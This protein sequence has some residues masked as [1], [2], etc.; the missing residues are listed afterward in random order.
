MLHALRARRN[1]LAGKRA[2]TLTGRRT[3]GGSLRRGR[4]RRRR[5][6]VVKDASAGL[7]V[8]HL[9]AAGAPHLLKYVRPDA[10]AARRTF[11]IAD[12]GERDAVVLPR[13]AS[14]M[15]QHI[16]WNVGDHLCALGV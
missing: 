8:K 12:F 9:L 10:H 13:K 16:F 2:L 6:D 4:R 14:V 7:A 15:V 5:L 1:R 11:F 3:S